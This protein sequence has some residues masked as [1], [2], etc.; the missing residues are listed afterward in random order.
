[1]KS[2]NVS[3]PNKKLKKREKKLFLMNIVI[4]GREEFLKKLPT[5]KEHVQQTEMLRKGCSPIPYTS[6]NTQSRKIEKSN[7]AKSS[8]FNA[9]RWTKIL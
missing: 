6:G 9:F 3:Y 2:I 5:L 4:K 8:R 7:P 1:M